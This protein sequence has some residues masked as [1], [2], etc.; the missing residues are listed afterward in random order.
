MIWMGRKNWVR[1]FYWLSTGI[2]QVN[3][4]AV[5][6]P[7]KATVGIFAF[8]AQILRILFLKFFCIV[9]KIFGFFFSLPRFFLKKFLIFLNIF[10]NIEIFFEIFYFLPMEYLYFFREEFWILLR[11]LSEALFDPKG[12]YGLLLFIGKS[13]IKAMMI[14]PEISRKR[15]PYSGRGQIWPLTAH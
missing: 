3:W 9:C 2:Q 14:L 6:A 15:D 13:P 1:Y 7:R 12:S 10:G 5:N 8:P 11:R 4:G